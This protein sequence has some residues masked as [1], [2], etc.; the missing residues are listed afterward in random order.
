[1]SGA[2]GI[3]QAIQFFLIP[4]PPAFSSCPFLPGAAVFADSPGK[5]FRLDSGVA[6]LSLMKKNQKSA[7]QRAF[8]ARKPEIRAAI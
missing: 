8:Q 3:I 1:L 4:I 2:V 6:Q 5:S 7:K